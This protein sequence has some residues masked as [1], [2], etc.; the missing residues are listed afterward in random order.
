MWATVMRLRAGGHERHEILHMLAFVG[1]ETF[2]RMQLDQVPFDPARYA[3]DLEALPESWFDQDDDDDDDDDEIEAALEVLAAEGP[4]SLEELADRLDADP[5]DIFFLDG[6]PRVTFLADHR[7]ASVPALLAGT[8][9]THRVTEEEAAGEFLLIGVDLAPAAAFLCGGDHMHLAGGDVADL[10]EDDDADEEAALILRGPPGWLSGAAAGDVIGIK[11]T[12]A[13]SGSP[14]LE[15]VPVAAD[16][17][18]PDILAG[19]LLAGFGRFGE[20]DG[21]PVRAEELLYQLA[22]DAPALVSGPMAP[23]SEI[24]TAARFEV[25][26][27]YAAPEGADWETFGRVRKATRMATKHGLTPADAHGLVL[28]CELFRL[29]RLEHLDVSGREVAREVAALLQEPP[30]AEAF[31][32]AESEFPDEAASFLSWVRS[33]A[34]HRFEAGVAWAQSLVAGRAGQHERAETCLRIALAADPE[35]PNVLEDAAWYASDR[36]HAAQAL[37]LLERREDDL[38]EDRKAL[39]HRYAGAEP[40]AAVGR[41]DPCPCGSGKK[42]KHCC[43]SSSGGPLARPLPDRVRWV[44]EKLRWWIDR[45]GPHDAVFE[46]A[47]ALHGPPESVD[48]LGFS[49][50]Y[51]LAASLV[52]FADGAVHDFLRQRGSLL[53]ADERNLVGQWASTGTSLYDIVDVRR[54]EGLD[55]RDRRT[56]AVLD[57][58]ERKGSEALGAGQLLVGHPVPD[59]RGH[60]L[61]G[62][63]VRVFPAFDL[64]IRALLD[65]GAPAFELALLLDVARRPSGQAASSA[66]AGSPSLDEQ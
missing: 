6:E 43:L 31:A 20:G 45:F 18:V 23:L 2:R 39:L 66:A 61:V 26:D 30:V 62:G 33:L 54:G 42:F 24:L 37:R 16:M 47:F 17:A 50:D 29:Y 51:D 64:P 27:G 35:H 34:G 63:I 44:W 25:R 36:G 21:M 12:G 46:V 52:L 53:P 55:L 38:D 7:L 32:D 19:H 5:D 49:V 13:T 14:T 57:V 60:Q 4:L 10:D 11:L 59:G 58:T 1:G 3:A 8:I 15:V 48:D 9:L 65:A 40:V 56:G 41:N 22:V 28:V